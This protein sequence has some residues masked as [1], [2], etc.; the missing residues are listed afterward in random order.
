L[1]AEMAAKMRAEEDRLLK[2]HA[3]IM[4]R[5]MAERERKLWRMRQTWSA[6]AQVCALAPSSVL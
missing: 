5:L 1:R 2:R 6:G 4:A 3:D